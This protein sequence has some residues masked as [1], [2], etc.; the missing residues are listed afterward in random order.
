MPESL[1]STINSPADLRGLKLFVRESS[2]AAPAE[3]GGPN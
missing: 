2:G 3:A 1:L